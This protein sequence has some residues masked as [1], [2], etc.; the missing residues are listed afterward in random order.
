MWK[1]PFPVN[2]PIPYV[3]VE[4]DAGA[5]VHAL[6][7]A[8]APTQVLVVSDWAT[9]IDWS[10]QWSR[11][12]GV[13]SRVERADPS[14]FQGSDATGFMKMMLETGQFMEELGFTGGDKKI[15]MPEEVSAADK[16][17]CRNNG[18]DCV[19]RWRNEAFL[20]VAPS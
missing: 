18:T 16:T 1:P 13:K 12:T 4:K 19:C 11:V 7:K 2:S 8:P 3:N 5:F 14:V 9:A 17:T 15:L 6:I 10:E 20:S